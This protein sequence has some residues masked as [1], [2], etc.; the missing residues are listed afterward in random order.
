MNT[1]SLLVF[2]IITFLY[3]S[4]SL[5]Y[6]D[7]LNA[8]IHFYNQGK[9]AEAKKAL[10]RTNIQK[11][12]NGSYMM[13]AI[14][15]KENNLTEAVKWFQIAADNNLVEAYHALG[16]AYH[17]LWQRNHIDSY[18]V[19]S[20]EYYAKSLATG[21]QQAKSGLAQLE[22]E[23]DDYKQER[24]RIQIQLDKAEKKRIQIQLD[25]AEKKR[26]QIQLDKAEKKKIIAP[27]KTRK[28]Y[29]PNVV[30]IEQVHRNCDEM[31]HVAWKKYK[32]TLPGKVIKGDFELISIFG[33]P[34][35]LG[36]IKEVIVDWKDGTDFSAHWENRYFTLVVSGLKEQ[37]VLNLKEGYVYNIS[38]KIDELKTYKPRRLSVNPYSHRCDFTMYSNVE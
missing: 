33:G 19:K 37:D 14:L 31:N 34:S 10:N 38:Y 2:S 35:E 5:S 20:K 24:K 28:S 23:Y 30:D 13:G 22:R 26:I 12:P 21:F 6:D 15:L 27:K 32:K 7:N 17:Q 16:S 3:S 11:N 29:N 1:I 9:Y 25:K 4:V 8:A 36:G 18:Y